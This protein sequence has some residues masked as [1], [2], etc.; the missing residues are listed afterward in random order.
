MARA[1][2][3]EHFLQHLGNVNGEINCICV[4]EGWGARPHGETAK[5]DAVMEHCLLDEGGALPNTWANLSADVPA[6]F[7]L[8][9]VR[10]ACR[11]ARPS[12]SQSSPDK[13]AD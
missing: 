9:A 11:L 8:P 6:S 3:F 7:V 5:G 10:C 12:S 1:G 2:F 4:R 13:G